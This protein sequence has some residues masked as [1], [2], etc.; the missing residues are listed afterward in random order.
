M[1]ANAEQVCKPSSVRTRY[2][3]RG[4][5]SSGTH[6][7]VRLERSTRELR[8]GH[9]QTLPYLTLLRVGF[10]RPAGCPTAGALLPHHFTLASMTCPHEADTG[11]AV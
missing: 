1:N 8:A 9:P 4:G 5:H 6:V 2:R 10:T 7:T 11:S 3:V